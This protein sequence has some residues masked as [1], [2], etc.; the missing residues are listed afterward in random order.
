M[1][2]RWTGVSTSWKWKTHDERLE[3][4]DRLLETISAVLDHSLGLFEYPLLLSA[5]EMGKVP[6]KTPSH[7]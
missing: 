5:M 4:L 3:F 1:C 2:A 7:E 6:P